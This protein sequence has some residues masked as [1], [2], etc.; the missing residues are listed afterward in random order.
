[1]RLIIFLFV[2]ILCQNKCY[3]QE[4]QILNDTLYINIKDIPSDKILYMLN[5]FGGIGT[6]GINI[7]NKYTDYQIFGN[8]EFNST[9]ILKKKDEIDAKNILSYKDY[10]KYL[11]KDYVKTIV[12]YKLFFIIS[13][14]KL[15]YLLAEVKPL[16]PEGFIEM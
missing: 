16:F 13:D 14:D 10:N 15:N 12:K 9:F 3:S 5:R 8:K 11:N 2:S 6:V 1:M 4:K 7:K